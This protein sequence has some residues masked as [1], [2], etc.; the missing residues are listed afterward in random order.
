M[1]LDA[2][3][4]GDGVVGGAGERDSEVREHAAGEEPGHRV[5]AAR[6]GVPVDVL[7]QQAGG[8]A[9]V[10]VELASSPVVLSVSGEQ[11]G[12]G[13]R[14]GG[15][16]EVL[17]RE[18]P[19]AEKTSEGQAEGGG[20]TGRQEQVVYQRPLDPDAEGADTSRLEERLI[21]Q[22]GEQQSLM[23]AQNRRID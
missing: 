9:A 13:E 2:V 1:D 10:V 16:R 11:R 23:A 21:Q 7:E 8:G 20:E 3:E 15:G 12:R 19:S 22:I 4:R 5:S 14:R 6:P 18:G 17:P